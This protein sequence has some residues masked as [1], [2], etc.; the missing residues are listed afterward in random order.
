ML[1]MMRRKSARVQR[2]VLTGLVVAAA[3]MAAVPALATPP[4]SADQ[5]FTPERDVPLGPKIDRFDYQS[6]DPSTGRLF[7]SGMSIGKLLVFDTSA[8]K[9]LTELDGYPEVTGVLAVPELHKVYAS[10]PGEGVLLS[11]AAGLAGIGSG[12][13]VI[14]D[15]RTLHEIARVPGGVFPNGITF[16]PDDR[17]IFVT[18]EYGR[19]VTIIDGEAD[20]WIGRVEL[21]GLIGNV[22]YDPI[23]KRVYAAVKTT[24]EL[25]AIDPKSHTVVARYR[26]QGGRHPHGVAIAPGSAIGFV[27]CDEDDRL[28]TV[29]LATGRVLDNLPIAHKPDVLAIDPT[30]GRLYIASESGAL[31]VL[32]IKDAASPVVIATFPFAENA[33]SVGVDPNSHRVFLPLRKVDGRAVLRILQPKTVHMDSEGLR[34]R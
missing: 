25:V 11:V 6:L 26:L 22:Q 20:R 32:D 29:A 24:N 19:G 28:L 30:L 9:L 27:A 3:G 10:V 8:N 14:L 33:H 7:V 2:A 31:S 4:P 16:D 18:D 23:T 15:S 12:Q 34:S 17:T 21:G 5:L 1:A 13:V